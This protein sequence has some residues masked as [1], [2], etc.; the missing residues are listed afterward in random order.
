MRPEGDGDLQSEP[1][2]VAKSIS[3]RASH[4]PSVTSS[5]GPGFASPGEGSIASSPQVSQGDRPGCCVGVEL[6][7]VSSSV[8][9]TLTFAGPAPPLPARCVGRSGSG[10]V[11]SSSVSSVSSTSTHA[12]APLAVGIPVGYVA[13]PTPSREWWLSAGTKPTL[14]K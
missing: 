8:S 6:S 10:V 12:G 7:S 9:S 13:P 5:V 3:A 1:L 14:P 4:L 2:E 11:N